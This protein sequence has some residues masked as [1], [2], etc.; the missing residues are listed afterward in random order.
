[1]SSPYYR[2]CDCYVNSTY[3]YIVETDDFGDVLPAK[4][5]RVCPEGQAVIYAD[6]SVA[7]QSYKKD[8]YSCQS[9]PDPLMYFAYTS[10]SYSCQCQT[11]YTKVGQPSI[12]TQSCVQS[13]LL[14]GNYQSQEN[15]AATVQFQSG[16][17]LSL[18]ILH[19]YTAA[20]T[21]CKYHGT[22][23]DSV[24]CQTLANLCVLETYNFRSGSAC[25]AFNSILLGR[26]NT[27]INGVQNWVPGMPWLTYAN[28]EVCKVDLLQMRMKL[29]N[30][31]LQYVLSVYSLNG[32]WLG[33][34]ELG[35]TLNYCTRRAPNSNQGGGT[36]SPTGWE[37]FGAYQKSMFQ[38][39]LDSLITQEQLF[40]ELYVID[41]KTDDLLPVPVRIVQ[42]KDASGASPN[43][44]AFESKYQ[45][46]GNVLCNDG[47]V[48]VR[49]FSLFNVL[50]GISTDSVDVN[51]VTYPTV[52]QFADHISLEVSIRSDDSQYIYSPVL[53]IS[54]SE[55]VIASWG[56][57]YETTAE[58]TVEGSYT[59][60]TGEVMAHFL[61]GFIA[62]VVVI[63]LLFINR[64]FNWQRRTL[65]PYAI[66][67]E[68]T[69]TFLSFDDIVE[70][71][72]MAMHSVVQVGFPAFVLTTF[73]CFVFYKMQ[74]TVAYMLPP[75][76]DVYNGQSSYFY[77]VLSLHVLAL[78]QTAYMV[79]VVYKQTNADLFF[80]DWEPV[81]T[82]R[83]K[84][85]A[86]KKVSVWR[87]ILVANEWNELTAARRTDIRFT[88]FWILFF[89]LGL[90]LEYNATQ[91]PDLDDKTPGQLNIVL[92]FA[93]T[94]WWWFV[95]SFFQWA[96][97]FLIYERYISEPPEQ[98]F[99]DLCTVAKISMLLLDEPYHGFYL[100]CRSPHQF[101]D[102]SME[103]LVEMLH[104]E[105]AG[106][107]V[108]RSMDGAPPDVQS[109]ELYVT[110]EWR[111][112]FNKLYGSMIA[113][114][115][116]SESMKIGAERGARS[117]GCFGQARSQPSP[118][119]LKAWGDLSVFLQEFIDNNFSKID[120]K[121]IVNEATFVERLLHRAPDMSLV[122][123]PNVFRPDRR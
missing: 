57:S 84:N 42:L 50:A 77:F 97:K 74:D 120:L 26:A 60:E 23:Q 30:K 58:Y 63:G 118:R 40:Y 47:D 20:V 92:R 39:D 106:L 94:T 4:Q 7:G 116:A 13:S 62:T 68:L 61:G 115:V 3:M 22:L 46:G 37:I 25:S 43:E 2:D 78:F 111:K 29:S 79:R 71:L 5:C 66:G 65:R 101:A 89:L 55:S 6:V 119:V 36:G 95:M 21:A 108:D 17:V 18:T 16:D 53:T 122:G 24:A 123:N 67:I 96:W 113:L 69:P 52:M 91:Q 81:S 8:L 93:N 33:Y 87:T 72:S 76:Y 112:K 44:A 80:L 83:G 41:T 45:S 11:G 59:M 34:S 110:V 103:E 85:A 10:G 104:K 31:L 105:E 32:T 70:V 38:C 73:Y 54:Y 35:T 19:Y 86:E 107:T 9:C 75:M 99:V 48:F 49:R 28:G 12:G 102:G 100:H 114:P 109:F 1:M 82:S 51:G 27:N 14:P 117:L 88:L 64:W 56:A 98:V 121:R 15:T 90:N